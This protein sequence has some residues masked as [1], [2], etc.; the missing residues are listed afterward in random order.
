MSPVEPAGP[1]PYETKALSA[2]AMCT[3]TPHALLRLLG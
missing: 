3:L 2:L 1:D